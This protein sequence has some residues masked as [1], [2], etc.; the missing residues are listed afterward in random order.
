MDTEKAGGEATAHRPSSEARARREPR[1]TPGTM[2]ADR[3]RIVALLGSG[4]MGEVY[5][6][7]DTKLGQ[8]VALKFLP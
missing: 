2:L 4:G 5:R 1:F 8:Q 7:D 3:Y 6:A